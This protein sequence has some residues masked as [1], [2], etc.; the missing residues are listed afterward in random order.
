MR[1]S[2]YI[3]ESDNGEII[4]ETSAK[5]LPIDVVQDIVNKVKVIR[6]LECN[7]L[8]TQL[9]GWRLLAIAAIILAAF[10]YFH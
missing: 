6:D 9:K 10:I 4:I 1:E 8:E 2:I 7:D 3:K 5:S